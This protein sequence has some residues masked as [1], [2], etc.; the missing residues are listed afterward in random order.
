MP[1]LAAVRPAVHA[2][3]EA[4]QIVRLYAWHPVGHGPYS[5]FVVAESEAQAKA[6]VEA[7][8]QRLLVSDEITQYEISGWGTDCFTL[9]V[10]EPGQPV[11]NA[12]D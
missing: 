9:T 8:Q 12:N 4:N 5:W 11:C 3:A 7:E 6:A 2:T 10:A 1:L